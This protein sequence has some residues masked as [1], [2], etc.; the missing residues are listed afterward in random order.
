MPRAAA[1]GLQPG[2]GNWTPMT[3]LPWSYHSMAAT[4][5]GHIA[6]VGGYETAS[7]G[8]VDPSTG[9]LRLLPDMLAAHPLPGVVVLSD[10][11]IAVFGG[12]TAH[13]SQPPGHPESE[14]YDPATN[15]WSPLETPAL[16]AVTSALT[17]PDGRILVS[18][19]TASYVWNPST[20]LV[21]AVSGTAGGTPLLLASDGYVYNVDNGQ[22]YRFDI[23]AM[24]W[25]SLVAVPVT[26]YFALSTSVFQV[27]A[28]HLLVL[29]NSDTATRAT[30]VLI[31]LTDL[32]VQVIDPIPDGDGPFQNHDLAG[33]G[34]LPD[35]TI[36]AMRG[37]G[38]YGGQRVYE[39]STRSWRVLPILSPIV[40][41]GRSVTTSDG[42]YMAG[43]VPERGGYHLT[44]YTPGPFVTTTLPAAPVI[45]L[46]PCC[47]SG[48][49]FYWA[50]LTPP[51]DGNLPILRYEVVRH[52]AD[53][54]HVTE[55]VDP[56]FVEAPGVGVGDTY[57][58]RAVNALGT[59]PESPPYL[60]VEGASPGPVE[61]LTVA[62]DG[63]IVITW[64][65]PATDGGSPITAYEIYGSEVSY[66]GTLRTAVLPATARSFVDT[67]VQ[68]G[69]TYSYTIAARNAG[70]Y[71]GTEDGEYFSS[72]RE[73]VVTVTPAIN[74]PPVAADSSRSLPVGLESGLVLSASD[75]DGDALT[76]TITSGPSHGTL[77]GTAPDLTYTPEPGY[78]GPD[79]VSYSV[80]DGRGGSASGTASITLT[81]DGSTSVSQSVEP[82]QTL[83][84]GGAP[85][86]DQ[87]TQS[88]VTSPTAGTVSITESDTPA[89]PSGYAVVGSQYV[90]SAPPAS[91]EQPL[92]LAFL[93]SAASLPGGE[94]KDT[95]TIFRDGVAIGPCTDG[96]GQASPDPCVASRTQSGDTITVTVLSS[97]ASAWTVAVPTHPTTT[98]LSVSPASAPVRSPVTLTA[99]VDSDLGAVATGTVAFTDAATGEA[100]GSA[101]ISDGT[102]SLVVD[103]LR[104]GE[105]A[106]T[107]AYPGDVNHAPST[108]TA[109]T[110]T[111]TRLPVVVTAD[112]ATITYGDQDPTFTAAISGLQ[113]GDGLTTAPTCTVA[114]P[115]L[116]VGP[117][118]I[119]CAGAAGS[120]DY[121]ISYQAGTLTVDPALLTVAAADASRGFGE[122]NPSFTYTLSGFELGDTTSV[123][124]GTP[125]LTTTA[126]TA[127]HPGTYAIT[128]SLGTLSARNYVFAFTPGTLTVTRAPITITG[129]PVSA[130]V[131]VLTGKITFSATVTNA[132]TSAAAVGESVT[133]TLRTLTGST[134][135]CSAT[136]TVLGVATCT[137]PKPLA[138]ALA[139][140][141]RYTISVLAS[142]DH[143][144][145]TGTGPVGL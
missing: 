120:D 84:T 24:T 125:A 42:L 141:N 130:L 96:S 57:T 97:H 145:G 51:G 75:P 107:A 82:S 68:V 4:A 78:S 90:I 101:A 43:F 54:D 131:S 118:P 21:E 81:T 52:A 134:V 123:V 144:A 106:I 41:R 7:A 45:R 85:T 86:P 29:G 6:V 121:T 129:K 59:G 142:T 69:K 32:S 39:P 124:T 8:I 91:V 119:T 128:P 25:S 65:A 80:D 2:E 98:A 105:H 92:Q 37:G 139:Y 79:S 103:S 49:R 11:R 111:I 62:G 14:I 135:S 10:G 67:D 17:L 5:D 63:R 109:A 70:G 89:D 1:E 56:T 58:V 122:A 64:D 138:A 34:Q 114:G 60:A 88:Q 46:R 35:G 117:Y 83:S 20:G 93:V 143:L 127:S 36:V 126:T 16:D 72:A 23:A 33:S 50:A 73:V 40:D 87:P 31:D 76:F 15:S 95:L 48:V 108:S 61:N 71:I 110:L 22:L 9:L 112:D 18:A 53:G 99:T 102:A 137:S 74:R 44:R 38:G 28:L 140:P 104:P 27:D 113:P 47:A 13:A 100:L 26:S 133:F 136:T 94:D 55:V 116:D 66:F 132:L 30:S 19:T 115:H 12:L 77:A 3:R